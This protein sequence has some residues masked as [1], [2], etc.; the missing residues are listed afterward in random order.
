MA[1]LSKTYTIDILSLL[2]LITLELYLVLIKAETESLLNPW[3]IVIRDTETIDNFA[4]SCNI[5]L[6]HHRELTLKLSHYFTNGHLLTKKSSI[7]VQLSNYF[8]AKNTYSCRLLLL[9]EYNSLSLLVHKQAW[10]IIERLSRLTSCCI[11]RSFVVTSESISIL[12]VSCLN[13]LNLLLDF[14]GYFLDFFLTDVDSSHELLIDLVCQLTYIE[15]IVASMLR[16]D[17]SESLQAS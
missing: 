12:F 9:D 14:S 3:N 11:C 2:E 16:L 1:T 15:F 4:I 13:L 7:V 10:S 17:M 8:F 6:F 5:E